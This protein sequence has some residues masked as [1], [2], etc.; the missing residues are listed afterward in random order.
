MAVKTALFV[1]LASTAAVL[2]ACG[3]EGVTP[4]NCPVL[5][6]ADDPDYDA[7]RAAAVE[8]GCA[9]PIGTAVS[10]TRSTGGTGGTG[11]GGTTNGAGG[12][13]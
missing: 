9:T 10:G 2:A 7:K 3:E 8:A 6:L 12:A 11:S 1:V 5:P 4:K 13:D